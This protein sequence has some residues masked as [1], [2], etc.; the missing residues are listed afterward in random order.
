MSRPGAIQFIT[1]GQRWFETFNPNFLRQCPCRY[2]PCHEGAALLAA[3]ATRRVLR[4]P[5][6]AFQRLLAERVVALDVLQATGPVEGLAECTDRDVAGRYL[7]GGV[8]VTTAEGGG[9]AVAA[10]LLTN[11][12]QVMADEADRNGILE[13]LSLGLGQK[14]A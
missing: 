9:P 6:G 8:L 3:Y 13:G 11:A 12:V 1:G 2:R 5:L 10:F 14:A 4:L 7:V